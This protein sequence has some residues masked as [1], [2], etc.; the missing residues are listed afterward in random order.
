MATDKKLHK[1]EIPLDGKLIT[2]QPPAKIGPNFQQ[3][4][5]MRYTE[6]RYRGCWGDG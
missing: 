6:K 4:T 3:L 5:N 2:S 1:Y